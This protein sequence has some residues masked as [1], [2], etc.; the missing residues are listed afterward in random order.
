M[1]VVNRSWTLE[2]GSDYQC[3]NQAKGLISPLFSMM[4]V[5]PSEISGR[6][7]S[8]ELNPRTPWQSGHHPSRRRL[9]PPT[10]DLRRACREWGD[11]PRFEIPDR[12]FADIRLRT[13]PGSWPV[14]QSSCWTALLPRQSDHR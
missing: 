12:S 9:P 11:P 3:V 1:N 7:L 8:S 2:D 14:S 10:P 4:P 13:Q 6:W 5:S